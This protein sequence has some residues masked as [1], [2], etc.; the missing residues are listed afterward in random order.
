MAFAGVSA[1]HWLQ[2]MIDARILPDS[3]TFNAVL[4]AHANCGDIAGAKRS[5][6]AFEEYSNEEC[7]NVRPDL[8]SYNT[9]ISACANAGQPREAE[10][11]FEEM[12]CAVS[13]IGD[14]S[15]LMS[16]IPPTSSF[17]SNCS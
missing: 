10:A 17:L 3:V 4:A 15:F 14:Q 1:A 5:L 16:Q 11:V 2:R 8:I 9:L 13:Y 6:R 7:P 12:K